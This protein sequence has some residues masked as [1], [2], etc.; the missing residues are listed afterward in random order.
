[1]HYQVVLGVGVL[2]LALGWALWRMRA[3]RASLSAAIEHQEMMS[4]FASDWSWTQDADFRFT[5]FEGTSLARHHLVLDTLR[6]KRRWEL[7]GLEVSE[8]AMAAHRA[9]C[10]RHEPFYEFEYGVDVPGMGQRWLVVSGYPLFD[11]AGVFVGYR[12][13]SRDDT[14]RHVAELAL[15]ASEQRL[16]A[17]LAGSPVPVFAIDETG[18]VVAW[19]RGCELVMGVDAEA[20]I[21]SSA[22]GVP[23]YGEDRP[24]LAHYVAG[25]K[26]MAELTTYYGDA[27]YAV[28]TVPGALAAEGFFPGLGGQDR[29]LSFLAAPMCDASGRV[30]G[31]IETLQDVTAR[32]QAEILLHERNQVFRTLIDNIP[33]GVALVG[34]DL[35]LITWNAEWLR[36]LGLPA[37]MFAQG[38]QSIESIFRYMAERGDYGPGDVEGKVDRRMAQARRFERHF[39]EW[40]R[41][42]GTV[43]EFRSSPLAA[44]GAV[45]IF[46]DVT[47][48]RNDQRLLQAKHREL[49]EAQ[50]IAH[51]G[52]WRWALGSPEVDVSEEMAR[53]MGGRDRGD[54][55]T[56]RGCLRCLSVDDRARLHLPLMALIRDG[57]PLD[58]LCQIRGAEGDVRDVH[59]LGRAER[60]R[61]GQIVRLVGTVQDVTARREAERALSESEQKFHAIFNQTFQ[62]IGLMSPDGILLEANQTS[63][64]FA[65]V[66]ASEVIGRPFADG[67]WWRGAPESRQ[68]L[69]SAIKRAA[70][71]QFERFETEHPSADGTTHF[72]DFSLKPVFD[73]LGRVS[74][75]IPEGRDITSFKLTQAE[76]QAGREMFATVFDKS[77]VAMDLLSLT[78]HDILQVNAAW[79]RVLAIDATRAI[80]NNTIVLDLWENP[81]ERQ[82]FLDLVA[83]RSRVDGFEARLRRGDRSIGTFEISSCVVYLDD[84]RVLLSALV[85]VT[86]QHRVQEQVRA[87]NA[88]LEERVK[89]RTEELLQA[90]ERLEQAMGQLVQSEKLASLGA[91]VAGVAHE[92]NTPLGNALTVASALHAAVRQCQRDAA[93]GGLTR[94]RFDEFMHTS[95]TAAELLERNIDRAA[96]QINTFKQVAVDQTS[97][98]RREFDLRD[99]VD[100]ALITFGPGLAKSP[101]AL[102]VDIPEALWME[103]YPGP[104]GQ[105]LSNLVTNA[106]THAFDD[107]TNGQMVL[108]A[109]TDGA[110]EVVFSFEDNGRGMSAEVA[111]HIFDPFYTTRLG[112]GGSGL[113]LYIVYNVITGILGGQVSLS[114]APGEGA[115]FVVRLPRLAPERAVGAVLPANLLDAGAD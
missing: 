115:C 37:E 76:L 107:T 38:V 102:T 17:I 90:K 80:G 21:G 111:A 44:G 52:S 64:D 10:E 7:P 89:Q 32:K 29:W 54:R 20:M 74:L 19:N 28:D 9:C 2:V 26:D 15:R 68:R 81:S 8:A 1:M 112:Q 66:P 65:G 87:L 47:A 60:T 31:A 22:P 36:L 99:I 14:Q 104:L 75:L 67:P 109:R 77:P 93:A 40:A 101:H 55:H 24:V 98:R 91:V 61:S 84:Q 57:L 16:A 83:Q 34:K 82:R 43:L 6:G 70:T 49:E 35:Q 113:G 30:I 39:E 96:R 27:V 12:G 3:L 108:R 13:L 85:D 59:M 71:G 46:T 88:T 23:F 78:Q 51:I 106:L 114:T 94:T 69:L 62:F 53:F 5:C 73:A 41:L 110:D 72:V 100:E 58:V 92:L 42:D 50:R 63:L 56:L 18:V 11:D 25:L 105:V 86:E 103:S 79:E 4:R 48:R 33:A 95:Q 45:A 97:E